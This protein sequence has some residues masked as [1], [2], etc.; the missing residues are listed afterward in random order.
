MS[1]S[2][3]CQMTE[4]LP[5]N[6]PMV[7]QHRFARS[8]TLAAWLIVALLAVNAL[9]MLVPPDRSWLGEALAQQ[10]PMMGA[11]G[12][13]AFPLQMSA[14]TYGICM[15]DVDA[16]T[17]WFYE[18]IP[19]TRKLRLVSSRSWIFD[20]YL[21]EYNVEG[22]TPSEVGD[23]VSRQRSQRQQRQPG[24]PSPAPLLDDDLGQALSPENGSSSD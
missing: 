2:A 12:V 3:R 23:L 8:L 6:L 11:R 13:H 22:L 9:L 5:E 16:G 10:A 15:M 14:K 19:T 1:C 20:R 7:A 4:G 21:E 18:Y 24:E 17:V